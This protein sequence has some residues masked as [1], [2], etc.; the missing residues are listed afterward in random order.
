[1]I[2]ILEEP[3]GVA[4][5]QLV[6][7]AFSLCDEFILVK[8]DQIELNEDGKR[9]IEEI[10]PYIKEIKKQEGWPGTQLFGHYADVFYFDCNEELKQILLRKVD[11]LYEWL[12]PELLEDLCFYKNNK[13]WLV[14]ITHEKEG[15]IKT[16]DN[17][18]ILMIRE[19]E[20]IMIY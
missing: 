13:E 3:T 4:Y 16:T 11:R 19:I 18:E 7:L 15:I 12:Q 14:T 8:R 2:Q 6:S 1:M 20:G 17:Q 10:K 5:K 9:F